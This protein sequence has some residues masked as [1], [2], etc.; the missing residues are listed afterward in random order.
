MAGEGLGLTTLNRAIVIQRHRLVR[1]FAGASSCSPD[2][3]PHF[4]F[5]RLE[6]KE[7]DRSIDR[8]VQI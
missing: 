8:L 4:G 2:L 6:L 1:S 3:T 5:P 7:S